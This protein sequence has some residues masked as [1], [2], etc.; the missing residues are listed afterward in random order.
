VLVSKLTDVLK[1]RSG[2]CAG[3]P[4]WLKGSTFCSRSITYPATI[5]TA[6]KTRTEIV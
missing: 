1:A 4:P 3:M 6:A 2:D 5:A